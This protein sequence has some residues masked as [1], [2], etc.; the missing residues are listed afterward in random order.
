MSTEAD[1]LSLTFA[2]TRGDLETISVDRPDLASMMAS[3]RFV[4]LARVSAFWKR[5]EVEHVSV[6]EQSCLDWIT[7]Q[8]GLSA[9][10]GFLI[11]GTDS[12]VACWYGVDEKS[13]GR[14]TLR[15]GFLATFPDARLVESS[16]LDLAALDAMN[17]AVALTGTPSPRAGSDDSRNGDQIERVC[18]GLLGQ[19]WAYVVTARPRTPGETALAIAE[20]SREVSR[21]HAMYLLKGTAADEQNRMALRYVELLDAKLHRLEEGR[22]TG[23]WNTTTLLLAEHAEVAL[24]GSGLLRSAFGGRESLPDPIRVRPAD[25]RPGKHLNLEPSTSGEVARLTRPPHE[26]YPGYEVVDTMR[27]G[28]QQPEVR[29]GSSGLLVGHIIDRGR[30]TGGSFRI[31]SRELTKHALVVGVT[32]SGKTNTCMG[33]LDQVWDAGRGVPF[34]VVESAKSE[35]R[36]LLRE[37]RFSGLRVF[38]CGDETGSPLR[39][40]PLEFR[41]GVLVQTHVDFLKALFGAAFVLY[42][43][44]PYVL[45]QS[46]QEVYQDRGWD[47]AWS[48]NRRGSQS[49][50]RFPTL[51]DLA[52]KVG[53]VIARM[54]YDDRIT[55]DVRA[56]LLARIDQLRSGGGKGPMFGAR[57]SIPDEVLFGVPC[58][59]ELK[60]LVSDDEKAFLIG[61]L[62][63]RLYEY[64]EITGRLGASDLRHVT[65]IEEAHRLLRNVS[66]EQGGEV[67]ANPRGKAIEVFANILSE[68][69]AYGEGI[70]IAEQIP[71]KLTPDALKNTN[72]KIVHRTVAEDDR[73]SVGA[74]MNLTD[75]QMR[76]L[77]TLVPGEAAV[78]S[79]GARKAVLVHVPLRSPKSNTLAVRTDEV[80]HAMEPFWS[81][82]K[83]LRPQHHACNKCP[84]A[85]TNCASSLTRVVASRGEVR[86]AFLRLW[87]ALRFEKALVGPAFS[88][89]RT[90]V[91]RA[92]VPPLRDGLSLCVFARLVESELE[93]RGQMRAWSFEDMDRAADLACS[94]VARTAEASDRSHGVSTGTEGSRTSSA[95]SALLRRL[96]HLESGPFAGC[97]S[98]QDACEFRVEAG[99]STDSEHGE[100]FRRMF[101]DPS[102]PV[103]SLTAYGVSAVARFYMAKDVASRRGAALC[104]AVQQFH[105]LGLSEKNQEEMARQFAEELNRS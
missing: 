87:S 20:L 56:G 14:E 75:D 74:T 62:L 32:G 51:D 99:R 82:H 65:L 35:Y 26:D 11:V 95:L 23:M 12:E 52:E 59:L 30:P 41:S 19:R 76:A 71:A 24:R 2:L 68:I 7:G 67:H 17:H 86:T 46:L 84:A 16:D 77:V 1:L 28:V 50:R 60:Q 69:R 66:S 34:L 42:P 104:F 100:D 22:S 39:L 64:H 8:H 29:G 103:S 44:M 3:Y 83:E 58:L 48:T 54:G 33:L 15:A 89:F 78:Y 18:R 92:A 27:F 85:G 6:L 53:A 13:G 55:M 101:L 9:E 10:W 73:R 21:V 80:R 72:L 94:V 90:R 63:I 97:S 45:E 5:G 70:V 79:E 81:K 88:E 25:R 98:C 37:S 91:E 40:N 38:T 61:L 49:N 102:V 57:R 4:R 36:A 47:L 105:A 96:H 93:F 31:D 43:P